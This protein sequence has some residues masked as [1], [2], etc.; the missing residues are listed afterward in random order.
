MKALVIERHV[1]RFAAARTASYL[2]GSGS[3]LGVGPLRLIDSEALELPGEH[4]HRI[5]PRLAGIC[6]SDLSTVDGASSRYF[7]QIVSFPFVL[8]HEIVGELLD[9]PARGARVVVEPVLGCLARGIEPPCPACARGEK[10]GCERITFGHLRP[11][12]QTGYCH[13]T[14][15]GWSEE[16]VVHDSQIH[17]VPVQLS[18]EAAVMVEP[19]ACAVHAALKG[20]VTPGERVVVIGAGT[21]GLT[22]TA[23]LRHFA[24][25]GTLIV[26]A[27]Y[28][29]QREL[30]R[31]LGADIVV[32]PEELTRT[33][34][35]VS[36]SLAITAR[37][38]ERLTGGADVVFDCVGSSS[39]LAQSLALVRP[40]GR[41]VLVGMPAPQ[42]IDLAPLWQREI[43][44]IG[45]YAYGTEHLP[46]G[47]RPTFE[48]AFD[49]VESAMLE[50][51]VSAHYPLE[52][53]E[54]AI[55][56]A[57]TAGR[58]GATKIVFDLRPSEGSWQRLREQGPDEEA[59]QQ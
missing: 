13:D 2:L 53:Y 34:R 6:G 56:H 22:L 32:A 23:A 48:L 16:L 12:L 35:R 21:L 57:G 24:L 26:A 8:G 7:E 42:R 19:T 11:G 17:L 3:G 36:R 29:H 39:S 38:R 44:L 58:R 54:D 46:E 55:G 15:G 28:S 10:G 43:T 20:D 14:G 4:W 30:A 51:L 5:A 59:E 41:I 33:T 25:P 52:R 47:P 18:D 49:L 31:Q 40:R 37:S 45:A 9:G 1:H 50:R 27:K